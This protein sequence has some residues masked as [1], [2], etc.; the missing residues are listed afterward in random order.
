MTG[1]LEFYSF[2]LN[3]QMPTNRITRNSCKFLAVKFPM[4]PIGKLESLSFFPLLSFALKI[5]VFQGASQ[6]LP[7]I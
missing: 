1:V 4:I 2:A 3:I 6:V 5:V 7:S